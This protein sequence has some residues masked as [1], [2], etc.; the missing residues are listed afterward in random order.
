MMLLTIYS[1]SRMYYKGE[2]IKIQYIQIVKKRFHAKWHVVIASQSGSQGY[3]LC[4]QLVEWRKVDFR[5]PKNVMISQ[6]VILGHM[7]EYML[8]Y[9]YVITKGT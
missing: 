3:S 7:P 6:C 2:E 1:G 4:I 9:S 8:W 5:D